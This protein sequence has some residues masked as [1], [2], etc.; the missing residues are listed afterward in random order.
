MAGTT[1]G[2]VAPLR[3]NDDQDENRDIVRNVFGDGTAK[4]VGPK[5]AIE[6]I[7]SS[8]AVTESQAAMFVAQTHPRNQVRAMDRI[9]Q[10]FTR[11]GLAEKALYEYARGGQNISGPSIRAAEA[12]AQNWGNMK[13][14]VRELDQRDGVSTVEA[15]SWDLET[16]V[17]SNRVFQ[18]AHERVTKTSRTRLTDPRDIYE[19]VANNGARRM[20][21]C[22]LQLI[23]S[24]VVEAA[25]AQTMVTLRTNIKV[26]PETITSL[27]EKFA[28]YGV[29]KAAL[30][31]R[32]QRRIE[33]ITPALMLN[34]GKIY[35]S[36]KDEMSVPTDWFEI[37]EPTNVSGSKTAEVAA[38][39][40]ARVADSAR[41]ANGGAAPSTETPGNESPE[42][43]P[44]DA[45]QASGSG[46]Q[47]TLVETPSRPLPQ[48]GKMTPEQLVDAAEQEAIAYGLDS[49]DLAKIIARFGGKVNKA[50]VQGIF[51]TIKAEAI[52]N[53]GGDGA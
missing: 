10:A 52:A 35:N 44:A 24:D 28:A 18:V 1:V 17:S 15:F 16:N 43:P 20:R 50:N 47:T 8:R 4:T 49:P 39:M 9:L 30:E 33:S 26:T 36:L 25:V 14:G 46:E 40:A 27:I 13:F 3:S 34:L 42:A 31:T 2:A 12:L 22:I 6:A 19:H 53:G 32:I 21:A 37:A 7:E 41:S 48:F 51:E 5:S 38:Q 45:A 23:P 29:N 11:P